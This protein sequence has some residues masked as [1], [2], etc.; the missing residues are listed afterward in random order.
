VIDLQDERRPEVEERFLRADAP[1]GPM[2]ADRLRQGE[3]RLW[4]PLV[5]DF[6]EPEMSLDGFYYLPEADSPR[7]VLSQWIADF[8]RDKP[9][10]TVIFEN[11]P[12]RKG[13]PFLRERKEKVFYM[14]DRVYFWAA[15]GD[16]ADEIDDVIGQASCASWVIGMV[17]DSSSSKLPKEV[18]GGDLKELAS[19]AVSLICDAFDMCSFI[20]AE[21]VD[22]VSIVPDRTR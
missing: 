4:M 22:C 5:E 16:S 18:G 10:R 1:L 14:E 15:S 2:L 8:L 7:I 17:V 3:W 13:D 19:Q 9:G 11:D 21:M 12:A 6:W 20:V